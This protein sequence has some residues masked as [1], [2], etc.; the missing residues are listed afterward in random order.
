VSKPSPGRFAAVVV[1]L[2]FVCCLATP[3]V[4]HSKPRYFVQYGRWAGWHYK[5]LTTDKLP[6]DCEWFTAPI[7]NKKCHYQA[8]VKISYRGTDEV[9]GESVP[10]FGD[11]LRP[12][13]NKEHAHVYEPIVRIGWEKKED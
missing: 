1:A 11:P 5:H 4:V 6:N 2:L 12:N 10:D 9:T 8:N 3:L 7:G 13:F